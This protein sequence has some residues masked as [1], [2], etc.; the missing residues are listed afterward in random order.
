[1]IK[2]NWYLRSRARKALEL[3]VSGGSSPLSAPITL[4]LAGRNQ[5]LGYP[6]FYSS[7]AL[8]PSLEKESE[9]PKITTLKPGTEKPIDPFAQWLRDSGFDELPQILEV[10]K[11]ELRL[12]GVR[13]LTPDS[14]ERAQ[15]VLPRPL[16]NQFI[17]AYKATGPALL[18]AAQLSPHR[19]ALAPTN[20]EREN[21]CSSHQKALLD[22]WYAE[23]AS[24]L[25]DL[26]IILATFIFA[27]GKT[28]LARQIV[29]IPTQFT[30][31]T[32]Q[33]T[34]F[35]QG[36]LRGRFSPKTIEEFSQQME[37]A[38]SVAAHHL[39]SISAET[40]QVLVVGYGKGQ[41][42]DKLKQRVKG[43]S[44]TIL[45]IDHQ[46]LVS[47][48]EKR[49]VAADAHNLPLPRASFDLV[50]SL[51]TIPHTNPLRTI[52]ELIRVTKP[53]GLAVFDVLAPHNFYHLIRSFLESEGFAKTISRLRN[54]P[55][56]RTNWIPRSM[57]YFLLNQL[58]K[59]GWSKEEYLAGRNVLVFF[60]K[61]KREPN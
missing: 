3:V 57:L 13:A 30:P 9:K 2:E 8:S 56:Q 24:L 27:L 15:K 44:F 37:E 61:Q 43:V 31:E 16:F 25:L 45:D 28:H 1:M 42:T 34:F 18:G 35:T 14:L 19:K 10:V 7:P 5:V 58:E 39:G 11:G 17:E 26:E 40:P 22:C 33:S 38:T 20:R 29:G 49:R 21:G 53:N 36:Q 54:P 52:P 50:I 48:E 41:D 6:P 4:G 12:I 60:T 23:N 59:G 47:S 55:V 51:H 46:L 32:R